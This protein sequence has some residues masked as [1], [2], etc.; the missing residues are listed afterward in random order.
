MDS[1]FVHGKVH[2]RKFL[3]NNNIRW[4]EKLT[5]HEDSYFNCLCQKLGKEVK[6]CQN[7]FYLWKWRD[8]SVCRHDPKYILKTF[9]NMLE[10]NTAL[11]KEF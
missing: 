3:I 2:R 8:N 4:N 10:S 11:V 6:Y 1:T 5:I 7:P 9:N